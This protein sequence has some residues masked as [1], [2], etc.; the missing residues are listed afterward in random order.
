VEAR[1]GLKIGC[2]EEIAWRNGWLTNAEL[3]D[4][5]DPRPVVERSQVC[6][7]WLLQLVDQA[8]RADHQTRRPCGGSR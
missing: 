7:A 1:Q 2:V 4:L 5:A 8:E 3:A 6:R